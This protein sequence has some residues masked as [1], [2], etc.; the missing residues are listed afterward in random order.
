VELGGNYPPLPSIT[1]AYRLVSIF[2]RAT[3]S[4]PSYSPR[5]TLPL[6]L[7]VNSAAAALPS[8]GRAATP[9][10]VGACPIAPP[11]LPAYWTATPHPT[12][13]RRLHRIAVLPS[14]RTALTICASPQFHRSCPAYSAGAPSEAVAVV[15]HAIRSLGDTTTLHV[16]PPLRVGKQKAGRRAV[17]GP[18]AR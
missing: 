6:L 16:K 11:P 18:A 17:R 3:P 5:V 4:P 7:R 12:G 2:P 15:T 1:Q 8:A 10:L 14:N 13:W 9:D